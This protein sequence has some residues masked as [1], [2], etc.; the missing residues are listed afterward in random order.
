MLRHKHPDQ[1]S[2]LQIPFGPVIPTIAVAVSLWLLVQA[3]LQKILIGLGGLVIGVPFY[4]LMKNQYLS[5]A[6]TKE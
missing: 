4:L 5:H 1:P 3:D 2:S 6:S